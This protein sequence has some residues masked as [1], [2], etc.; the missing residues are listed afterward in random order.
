MQ[1]GSTHAGQ[2]NEVARNA[3]GVIVHHPQWTTLELRWLPTTRDMS[4]D[5]FKET[6]QLLASEGERLRPASMFVDSNEFFHQ[7][8]MGVMDWRDEHIIPRYNAAGVTRFAFL[9]PADTP[10]TV[11][12]G[13]VPQVEG[14]ATFSTGWF[15]TREKAYAW[16]TGSE[17][18]TGYA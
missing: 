4:D 11:E 18:A 9:V 2:S 1:T 8:G 17:G 10:N 16:L 13:A 7:P 3:W 14:P 12:S 6:L 5:G 15:T